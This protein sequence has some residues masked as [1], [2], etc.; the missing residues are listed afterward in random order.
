[1]KPVGMAQRAK[2]HEPITVLVE[3][4]DETEKAKEGTGWI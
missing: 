4:L 1:M 3:Q 2:G